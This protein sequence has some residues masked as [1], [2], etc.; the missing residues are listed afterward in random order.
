MMRWALAV[1]LL[2]AGAAIAAPSPVTP[3]PE[4]NRDGGRD[5]G[6]GQAVVKVLKDQRMIIMDFGSEVSW[7]SAPPAKMV[8]NVRQIRALVIKH[9]G[10]MPYD[11]TTLPLRVVADYEKKLIEV[12]LPTTASSIAANPEMWLAL[13][14]V[15]EET[16]RDL[17]K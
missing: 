6:A 15:I 9:F 3:Q 10:N 14:E 12:H 17:E 4:V 13:A 1:L 8:A 2:Q 16:A 5:F 7:V 11:K